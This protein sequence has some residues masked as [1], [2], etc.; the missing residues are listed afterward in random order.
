[1]RH[2]ANQNDLVKKATRSPKQPRVNRWST[3]RRPWLQIFLYSL[4]ALVALVGLGDSIYLTV[5][6]LTGQGVDCLASAGCETV[7]TSKYATVVKVPLAAFG[8][9]GYFSVFSF[10]T[11]AA[12]GRAWVRTCFLCLV[13]FMFGTTCWLFYLQ[14]FV[15]H[16]FCDYCLLSAALIVVLATIAI[17][18]SAS[19]AHR[20]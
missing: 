15:L 20:A 2:S 5:Q 4:A 7:L 9:A 17:A 14:A 11:L 6:H 16:A 12:F 8:A 1:M 13:G 19:R 10:A 18:V 3:A